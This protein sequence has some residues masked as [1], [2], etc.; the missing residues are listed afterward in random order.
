VNKCYACQSNAFW[1]CYRCD[2]WCCHKHIDLHYWYEFSS[3]EGLKKQQTWLC[4]ECIQKLKEWEEAASKIN[5]E[6]NEGG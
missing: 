5:N 2:N 6:D 1:K 4:L 3:T